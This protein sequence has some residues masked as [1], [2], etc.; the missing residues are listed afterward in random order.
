MRVLPTR[1]AS[2][3]PAHRAARARWALG[4][5]AAL[6]MLGFAGAPAARSAPDA[7]EQAGPGVAASGPSATIEDVAWIAGH[8]RGEALG[9]IA[10][11]V[12]TPPLGPSMMASFKLVVGDEVRFY[13][14]CTL[15]EENGSLML[16]LKH[17]HADLKGWEEKDE[18]VDFPL[19]ELGPGKAVFDGLRFERVSDDE[20]NVVVVTEDHE[21]RRDELRFSYHRVQ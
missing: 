5:A 15:T 21:G 2:R 14:L 17:F 18:T 8:W 11:E 7:P 10:E 13:E 3:R 20:M 4:A 16:R 1:P 9:G 12:W 19:L 6:A